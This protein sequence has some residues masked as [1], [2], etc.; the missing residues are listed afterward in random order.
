MYLKS[1]NCISNCTEW[2][3]QR[4]AGRV[5]KEFEPYFQLHWMISAARSWTYIWR[6]WTVFPAALNGQCSVELDVYLKSLNCISHCAEWSVQ[7]R[8]G[9]VFKEFEPYF[10]LRW[11]VSA[12]WSCFGCKS[13]CSVTAAEVCTSY[14]VQ[15][16]TYWHL[17]CNKLRVVH[18]SRSVQT[19]IW[20]M[21]CNPPV[22]SVCIYM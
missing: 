7:R 4:E 15:M 3:V 9:R 5:F 19:S 13:L 21:I 11:M 1:L 17:A 10:P 22:G 8:A 6:V 2:S 14:C 18:N 16:L 12:V 20:Y